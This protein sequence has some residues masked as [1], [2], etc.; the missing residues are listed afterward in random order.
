MFI[1]TALDTCYSHPSAWSSAF[2]F[3]IWMLAGGVGFVVIFGSIMFGMFWA[4]S[5]LDEYEELRRV[6]HSAKVKAQILALVEKIEAE[7]EEA[8]P[9]TT[10]AEAPSDSAPLS[11]VKE[12]FLNLQSWR[13]SFVASLPEE[14]RGMNAEQRRQTV[15]ML[16][17][18]FESENGVADAFT[19]EEICAAFGL[20]ME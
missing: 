14:N 1:E 9:C 7:R 10:S 6:K 8:T 3:L 4:G 19:E 12:R 17:S 2:D 18:Q 15:Q 13:K 16:N 11:E 5:R 20:R